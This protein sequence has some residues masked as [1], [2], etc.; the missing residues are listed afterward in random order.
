MGIVNIRVLRIR[1][2]SL[3]SAC[4]KKLRSFSAARGTWILSF[5]N[6]PIN[7]GSLFFPC[8][9]VGKKRQERGYTYMV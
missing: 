4:C 7:H 9:N 8:R 2:E 1:R 5:L 3:I 6:V